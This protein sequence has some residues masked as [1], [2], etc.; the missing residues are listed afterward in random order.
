MIKSN[1]LLISVPIA[2]GNSGGPVLGKYGLIRGQIT[3]GYDVVKLNKKS[4]PSLVCWEFYI[5]KAV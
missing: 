4:Y 2:S 3:A 1:L 5:C